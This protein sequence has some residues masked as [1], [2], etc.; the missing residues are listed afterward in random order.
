M[1]LGDHSLLTLPTDFILHIHYIAKGDVLLT[2]NE[3]VYKRNH[4]YYIKRV[5]V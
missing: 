4:Y 3:L 1:G 5:N 2:C